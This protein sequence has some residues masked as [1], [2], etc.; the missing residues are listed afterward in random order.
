M[1]QRRG[2]V[3]RGIARRRWRGRARVAEAATLLL[4]ASAAQKWVPMTR[5]SRS[6][7][8][9]GEVPAD[10]RGERVARLPYRPTSAT[11]H[12]V[13]RAIARASDRLPYEPTCLAQATAGQVML[14]RRGGSG[15]VVIGLQPVPGEEPWQAHAWLL[16]RAGALT[17]GPAARGFTAT[18]TFEVPD[19]LQAEEIDLRVGVRPGPSQA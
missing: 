9:H 2:T 3:Q 19:G 18:T 13:A 12:Y 4:L 14:R 5:W 10:W 8:Q 11:E 17:G 7:G 15:V 1:S 16:G 6:L